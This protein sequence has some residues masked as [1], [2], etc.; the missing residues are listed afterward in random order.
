MGGGSCPYDIADVDEVTANLSD[1][2]IAGTA[3]AFAENFLALPSV[4]PAVA[5]PGAPGLLA[6]AL[7]A[8]RTYTVPSTR[9]PRAA[10]PKPRG[11]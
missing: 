8:W 6:L 11:P 3:D 1:A 2:F 10:P 5:E 9:P 7:S 4:A